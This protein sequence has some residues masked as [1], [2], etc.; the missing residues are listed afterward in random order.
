MDN[1]IQGV[2]TTTV[3]AMVVA[4]DRQFSAELNHEAAPCWA[5]YC[6]V[7]PKPTALTHLLLESQITLLY[8][9]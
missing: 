4:C 3:A 2:T 8:C 7:L 1:L 6:Q 5:F 9:P